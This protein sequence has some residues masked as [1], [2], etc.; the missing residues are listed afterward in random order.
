MKLLLTNGD[1]GL[2]IAVLYFADTIFLENGN[3]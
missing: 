3:K 1:S 2:P